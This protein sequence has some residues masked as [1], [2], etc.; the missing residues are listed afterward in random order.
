MQS[1]GWG[2]ENKVIS[3]IISGNSNKETRQ[4]DEKEREE[5]VTTLDGLYFREGLS[6]EVGRE[7]QG[8]VTCGGQV[9][10]LGHEPLGRL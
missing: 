3:N 1:D 7:N 9:P 5:E 8:Q 6:E 2:R 4:W 10:A